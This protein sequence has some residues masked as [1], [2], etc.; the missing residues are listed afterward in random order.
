LDLG[1]ARLLAGDLK[2]AED[3]FHRALDLARQ[4]Q[5]RRNEARAL[6]SLGALY[7][8][9]YRPEEAKEFIDAAL[10]FYGQAGYRRELIQGRLLL[11]T[12]Q[13]QLGAY[14]EGAR[15][16]RDAL[17]DAVQ[18]QD[19]QLQAQAFERLGDNLGGL[20]DWPDALDQYQKAADLSAPAARGRFARL[21][22]A[23]LCWR[24]GRR[25]EARRFMSEA[26]QAAAASH[27]EPMAALLAAA[28]AEWFY[29]DGDFEKALAEAR[30]GLTTPGREEEAEARLSLIE[31]A[32]Y[33]RTG[34]IGEGNELTRR[35]IA[36]LDQ[37]K[38]QGSAADGRLLVAEALVLAHQ[39]AD[40][41]R[42]ALEALRFYQPRSIWESMWRCSAIIAKAKQ[43]SAEGIAQRASARTA[44]EQLKRKWPAASV[45]S[46]QRREDIRR[47]VEAAGIS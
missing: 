36:R 14:E 7:E 27:D 33:L 24:L 34:R 26:R 46:Y 1:N 8:Q 16:V 43:D 45:V 12:A 39:P 31:A 4:G 40:G 32:I 6:I 25:D 9:S 29:A 22:A 35:T 44:L 38:L 10:R 21:K 5:V 42:L 18:I 28:R 47:L 3:V 15:A 30:H 20:G 19:R 23:A 41:S 13:A 11:G 2:S 37:F 17:P